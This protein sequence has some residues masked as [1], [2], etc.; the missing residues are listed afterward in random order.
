[1]LQTRKGPGVPAP[2]PNLK[3]LHGGLDDTPKLLRFPL[4]VR[5]AVLRLKPWQRAD[6]LRSCLGEEKRF[7]RRPLPG[8]VAATPCWPA[9]ATWVLV[10]VER[11][12]DA[13]LVNRTP[14]T[15]ERALDQ[16]ADHQLLA[17]L[18]RAGNGALGEADVSAVLGKG[19]A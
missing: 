16:A 17:L 13:T 5:E 18:A 19:A 8:E 7:V 3:L 2:R 12:P 4:W 1:M 15:S 6:W 11:L 14:V 9:S 10:Q